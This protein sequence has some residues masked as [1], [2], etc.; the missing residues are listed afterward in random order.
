MCVCLCVSAC[1]HACSHVCMCTGFLHV[2]V[3]GICELMRACAPCVW[4][5]DN[6]RTSV[7]FPLIPCPQAASPYP[8]EI[9]YNLFYL[10]NLIY[11]CVY[12]CSKKLTRILAEGI[13]C[14]CEQF[15]LDWWSSFSGPQF[16]GSMG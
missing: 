1:V 11:L 9:S 2:C 4:Y 13:A 14:R 3:T 10:L 5:V 15:L 8:K 6:Q 7:P 16:P 12:V